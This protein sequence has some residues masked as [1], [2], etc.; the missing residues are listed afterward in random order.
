MCSCPSLPGLSDG[1]GS[2]SPGDCRSNLLPSQMQPVSGQSSC[3][4][5]SRI[6]ME[7]LQV[8]VLEPRAPWLSLHQVHLRFHHH[9]ATSKA[10][11]FIDVIPT[12][13]FH[14]IRRSILESCEMDMLSL[15]VLELLGVANLLLLL[16]SYSLWLLWLFWPFLM[17][18]LCLSRG[19]WEDHETPPQFHWWESTL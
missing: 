2:A 14:H 7:L 1:P 11:M 4:H 9:G 13:I 5:G 8:L 6:I 16:T 3:G 15:L 17:S 10:R 18:L 19:T 12:R